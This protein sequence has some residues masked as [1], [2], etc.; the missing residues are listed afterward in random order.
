[1]QGATDNV[2]VAVTTAVCTIIANRRG[3]YG[4]SVP[5][6]KETVEAILKALVHECNQQKAAGEN[7]FDKSCNAPQ[8]VNA[9]SAYFR[10]LVVDKVSPTLDRGAYCALR[11]GYDIE[12]F[13]RL[14]VTLWKGDY[15]KWNKRKT[16]LRDRVAINLRHQMVLRDEDL[17]KLDLS[18]CFTEVITTTLYKTPR[19]I[20]GLAICLR[21]GKTQ[22]DFEKNYALMFRQKD[23]LRCGV[24]AFAFY[25][26]ERF[27]VSVVGIV[28]QYGLR[29]G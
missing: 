11:D 7:H 14:M 1:M 26:F 20:P 6:G 25:M 13:Y 15:P 18:D 16:Y 8:V 3:T 19:S 22:A 12:A 9:I 10:K 27:M 2:I 4:I 24:G 29:R 28:L 17:R 5:I 21:S 23:Y